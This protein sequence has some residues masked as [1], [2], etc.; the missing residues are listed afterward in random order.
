[1]SKKIEN[2]YRTDLDEIN[3]I[4]EQQI[5]EKLEIEG[6]YYPIQAIEDACTAAKFIPPN[7][8]IGCASAALEE[9]EDVGSEIPVQFQES[10][11]SFQEI[12]DEAERIND[13]LDFELDALVAE[14]ENIF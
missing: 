10:G 12:T 4:G 5:M 11:R 2:P 6:K 9:I 8:E 14:L 1:M 13:E 3:V 7:E